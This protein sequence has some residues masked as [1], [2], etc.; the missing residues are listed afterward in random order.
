MKKPAVFMLSLVCTFSLV[1][2]GCS[3]EVKSYTDA[4]TLIEC[5]A[6]DEFIVALPANPSTGYSW[7]F[8]SASSKVYLVEK[9]YTPDNADN[10]LVGGGG[11]EYFRLKALDI[12]ETEL[13]FYY[14][15]PWD[16]VPLETLVIN[17]K[18]S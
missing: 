14:S 12:D 8:Q 7:E 15:R 2:P 10:T 4:D 1:F 9:T 6:G 17:L 11:T 13:W 5:R 3:P 16:S 18:V